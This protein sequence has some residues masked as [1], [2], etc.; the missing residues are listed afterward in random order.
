MGYRIL[1]V[2]DSATIRGILAK[3]VRIA[4]LP[5]DRLHEAGNGV[6][7]LAIL[8]S[9]P[10]DLVISDLHMP[11]MGGVEMIHHMAMDSELRQVPVIILTGDGSEQRRERLRADGVSHIL[12]KPVTPESIRDTIERVLREQQHG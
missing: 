12:R 6:D 10:V 7:A 4:G 1:F 8:R 9:H 3:I 11:T 2:D 5:V